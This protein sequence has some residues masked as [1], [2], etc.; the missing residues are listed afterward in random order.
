[1]ERCRDADQTHPGRAHVLSLFD[2]FYH[3]GPHGRHICIVS[4]FL[5]ESVGT[6]RLIIPDCKVPVPVAKE[7]SRQLLLALSYLHDR[8][9]I[10]HTDLHPRNSLL[11]YDEKLLSQNLKENP[12]APAATIDKH[13]A[14][15][16]IMQSQPLPLPIGILINLKLIDFSSANWSDEHW[17]TI[18]QIPL[19]RPP[20][21]ILGDEWDTSADIWTTACVIFKLVTGCFLFVRK[22][23]ETFTADDDHLA[24]MMEVLEPF[25]P[26]HLSTFSRRDSFFDPSG[27]LQRIPK[28]FPKLLEGLIENHMG[29]GPEEIALF[30]SFLRAMLRLRKEDRSSA[31][32]VLA[33]EWLGGVV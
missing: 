18:I 13:G 16:T 15:V 28:L 24:Q 17:A 11:S 12:P 21:I 31:V 26:S 14:S 10:T 1:M 22:E 3:D 29:W 7:L 25:G 6:L 23:S 27:N 9:N 4:E 2:H 20:E 33:H 32:Q 8:C 30:A 5:G 19:L